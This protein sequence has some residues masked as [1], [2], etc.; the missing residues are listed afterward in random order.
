MI[1]RHRPPH[2]LS[3]RNF[4][5]LFAGVCAALWALIWLW[6]DRLAIWPIAAGAALLGLAVAAPGVLMPLNR[7]WEVLAQ[8]FMHA[9]NF[10][11]LGIAFA[12]TIVPS[13]L[14]M[15]L[16]G[17]DPLNR[18]FEP[19]ATSYWTPVKR[20]TSAETLKDQF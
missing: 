9:T 6:G 19:G 15:R 16:L 2:R 4:G 11:L 13:G 3:D 17:H 12:A 5:F 8:R 1:A 20:G 18:R 7:L 10:I 14:I